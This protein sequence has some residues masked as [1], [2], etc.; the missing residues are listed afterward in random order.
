MYKQFFQICILFLALNQLSAQLPRSWY[1]GLSL[2]VQKY[3]L[4][5]YNDFNN[6]WL[7]PVAPKALVPNAISGG[8]V[9]GRNFNPRFSWQTELQYSS[10]TQKF[11]SEFPNTRPRLDVV[12]KLN[13]FK[14]PVI[15]QYNHLKWAKKTAGFYAEAG[16]Q[17]SIMSHY[18][19]TLT[20]IAGDSPG[21]QDVYTPYSK[22]SESYDTG[23][24]GIYPTDNMF[25]SMQFGAITGFGLKKIINEE[26]L[27]QAGIRFDYDFTNTDN[28]IEG[29]DYFNSN[30]RVVTNSGANTNTARK[31]THNIRFGL[32]F[33]ISYFINN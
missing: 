2:Q 1:G 30:L 3:W 4:Y 20:S 15:F 17:T 8:L 19:Q 28:F 32:N 25:K 22:R 10:Q 31:V 24:I 5:N 14:I 13:Y 18:K 23:Q 21:G 16:L 33:S 29:E 7:T 9:I 11:F 26:Y 6:P 27:L 12:C